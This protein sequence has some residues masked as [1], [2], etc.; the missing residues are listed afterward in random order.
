MS[1]QVDAIIANVEILHAALLGNCP[2]L[3][4]AYISEDICHYCGKH[5]PTDKAWDELDGGEGTNLCWGNCWST[6]YNV[7]IESALVLIAEIKRLRA[8]RIIYDII[9]EEK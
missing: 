7:S 2:A 3:D 6:Y 4:R 1:E 9:T 5:K 8:D